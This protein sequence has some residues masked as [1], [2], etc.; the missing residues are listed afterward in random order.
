V[1]ITV[2]V[3]PAAVRTVQVAPASV[4]MVP[5]TPWPPALAGRVETLDE[6]VGA[7]TGVLGV[8]PPNAT[9]AI[10][11]SNTPARIPAVIAAMSQR[12]RCGG[13]GGT[14]HDGDA[15]A[16][17]GSSGIGYDIGVSV[18]GLDQGN[19]HHPIRIR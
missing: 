1:T 6:G 4:T 16:V 7:A 14:G 3:L 18:A 17:V 5:R 2:T 9:Q 8:D 15:N 11:P 10:P 12:R 13:A 19:Q